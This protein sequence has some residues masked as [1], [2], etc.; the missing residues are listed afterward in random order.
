GATGA[1]YVPST[2]AAGTTYYYAVASS[3][4]CG[5]ATSDV[6]AVVVTP[7]TSITTQPEGDTY[8]I[9][10][11]ADGLTVAASGTGDLTYQWY[12]NTETIPTRR[13]S[14]L[15]ATGASYVPSTAAAGT[16]YY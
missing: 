5:S 7:A 9:A 15:G 10:A 3:A 12:S 13:S 6:V 2:A 4:T 8:C 1:S 11:Q 16:T 14:D